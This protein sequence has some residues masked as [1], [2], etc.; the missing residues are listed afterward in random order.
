M[1]IEILI[2]GK[3]HGMRDWSAVPA[4]GQDVWIKNVFQARGHDTERQHGGALKVV[5][6][7]WREDR[8]QVNLATPR[9]EQFGLAE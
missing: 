4:I 2:G 9:A 3:L 1:R 7:L 6:V 5:A 8:V